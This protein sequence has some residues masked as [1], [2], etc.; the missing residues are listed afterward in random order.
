MKTNQLQRCPKCDT[1]KP[2]DAFQP[3]RWGKPGQYCRFCSQG[4][5]AKYRMSGRGRYARRRSHRKAWTRRKTAVKPLLDAIKLAVGCV[6]CG[7]DRHAEALDFDH[8]PG[9]RKLFNI[10]AWAGLSVGWDEIFAELKKCEVVCAN[11]HRVRTCQ[12]RKSR[13]NDES[14]D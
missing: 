8:L 9:T 12:R 6:D 5:D 7:Y 13:L 14:E 2:E 4:A 1:E 11:C 3:S 10:G